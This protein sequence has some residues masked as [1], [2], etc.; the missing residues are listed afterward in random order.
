MAQLPVQTDKKKDSLLNELGSAKAYT[1]KINTLIRLSDYFVSILQYDSSL[2]YARKAVVFAENSKTDTLTVNA[3]LK[4]IEVFKIL[5]N[6]DS[7]IYYADNCILKSQETDYQKGLAYGYY[8]KASG[9]GALQKFAEA[10]KYTFIALKIFENLQHRPG[11]ASAHQN[12]GWFY[13]G[14]D[15]KDESLENNLKALYYWKLIRNNLKIAQV[16]NA[17]GASYILQGHYAEAKQYYDSALNYYNKLGREGPVWAFAYTYN[18]MGDLYDYWA[19]SL[20]NNHEKCISLEDS[21]YKYF[22]LSLEEWEKIEKDKSFPLSSTAIGALE[23]RLASLL[24]RKGAIAKA[25]SHLK[26]GFNIV[27]A[28]GVLTDIVKGYHINALIDSAEGNYREAFNNYRIYEI[29]KDSISN[30]NILRQAEIYKND[31]VFD[32]K[33]KELQLLEAKGKLQKTIAEKQSQR[34]SF[35]Y[36]FSGLLFISAGYGFYRYRKYSKQKSEQRR[37]KE[38][39][40]ISQDLHDHVGSTLSSISVFSKVAQVEG[41]KGNTGQMNE[42]LDR[43]RNTSGKM[44]TE[45]NDIVW[46]INPQNDTMEKI[47]QRMESFARPLLAARNMQFHFTYDETVKTLN[48]EMEQRKNFYLIFKEAV[49]NA[50]KYSGGSLLEANINC[51][52]E[53]LEL[54]VRDNGVGFNMEKEMNETKSL[55]GNGL[56]NMA[57]RAKEMNSNLV[58]ESGSGKGTFIRLVCPLS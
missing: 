10:I 55:S 47:I 48:L 54:L 32:K 8:W 42:L 26:K 29:Y 5:T 35:A 31:Y 12:L 43:I 14:L 37:L 53:T 25:K 20:K 34:R 18:G 1:G 28:K 49:N 7:V 4:L 50:I 17:V 38:R 16:S 21:A 27:K 41:E 56:K 44:M 24:L 9:Y 58:I 40:A 13:I 6:Y 33:E 11:I 23:M 30:V 36:L 3:W 15:K 45:M 46:A 57:A 51:R 52:Q 22:Q 2:G 39:L 19:E